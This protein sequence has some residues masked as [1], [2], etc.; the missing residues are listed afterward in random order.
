MAET[1]IG[2]LL[3]FP[4]AQTPKGHKPFPPAKSAISNDRFPFIPGENKISKWTPSGFLGFLL[5]AG[6]SEPLPRA[7]GRGLCRS[8]R[9]TKAELLGAASAPGPWLAITGWQAT[10]LVT[11]AKNPKGRSTPVKLC[12]T[13]CWAVGLLLLGCWA[14]GY[15]PNPK[16]GLN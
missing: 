3:V 13:S 12:K 16:N 2:F 7:L 11:Y 1:P 15:E 6:S 4:P 8:G 5:T 10:E 9:W 14:A